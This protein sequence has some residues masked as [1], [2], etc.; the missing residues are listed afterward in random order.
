MLIQNPQFTI[1]KSRYDEFRHDNKFL[2]WGQAFHQY[3]CLEK[4]TSSDRLWCDKLYNE[5]DNEKAKAMVLA[6]LDPNN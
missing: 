6:I 2:R 3:L 1:P 4:I 5:A